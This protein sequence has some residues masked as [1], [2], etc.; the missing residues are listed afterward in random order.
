MMSMRGYEKWACENF[1]GWKTTGFAQ[2]AGKVG[3]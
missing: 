2:K 3:D 1:Q